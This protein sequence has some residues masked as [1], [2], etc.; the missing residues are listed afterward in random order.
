MK[1][2]RNLK[3][4]ASGLIECEI[5]LGEEWHPHSIES[6]EEYELHESTEWED[7]K[8]LPQAEKD[9]YAAQ[10]AQAKYSAALD[11]V[12]DSEANARGYDS[13]KTAV[14]YADEPADPIFQAEGIAF[15]QW[16]SKA[17]RYGYDI[18]GQVQAG[19]IPLPSLD[20]FIAGIPALEI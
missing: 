10:E 16:R 3:E 6:H 18:L 20:D 9:A 13:I 7:V 8:P 5:L 19:E 17:Y 11:Q 4:H 12:L 14:T 15:R 2:L 1:T